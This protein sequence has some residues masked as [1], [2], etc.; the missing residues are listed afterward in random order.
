MQ[1]LWAIKLTLKPTGPLTFRQMPSGILHIMSYPF[2]PPTTLS[3]FLA[4]LL[5]L[6]DGGE[7]TGYGDDWHGKG[8]GKGH[9]RTLDPAYRAL[10][11]F[12]KLDGFSIHK[13]R[14][15]GPKNFKHHHFSQILRDDHKENFQLHHWDYLFCESLGGWVVAKDKEPL[16]R[17]KKLKNFGG[18]TGKEGWVFVEHIGEAKEM[19]L[20]EGE[21]VPLG[22]VTPPS[23]PEYGT[24]FNIYGHH[25]DKEYPWRNGEKGGV[26]GFTRV[27]A[28]WGAE[29]LSGPYWRWK[30]NEGF[31]AHVPDSFLAGDVEPFYE[32]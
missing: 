10:G 16:E 5:E 6:A 4:R 18:K 14:R 17:L 9:T 26:A 25:W 13:T 30:E 12:P 22:L 11:A 8:P 1:S 23:R 3:G 31:P 24:F 21:F 15:H 19:A 29:L 27:G 28:W 32:Q 20:R 2:M 7:W